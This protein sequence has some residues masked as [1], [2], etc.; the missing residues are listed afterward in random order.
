M[1]WAGSYTEREDVLVQ[2][3]ASKDSAQQKVFLKKSVWMAWISLVVSLV[4]WQ[5]TQ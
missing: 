4:E 3:T 1:A 5:Q 2:N